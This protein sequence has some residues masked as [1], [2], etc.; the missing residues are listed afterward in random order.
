MAFALEHTD[1]ARSEVRL[2][3]TGVEAFTSAMY[4]SV[5]NVLRQSDLLAVVTGSEALI[6][7]TNPFFEP[8]EQ[9]AIARNL[10]SLGIAQK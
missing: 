1:I 6:V 9:Q 10:E 5:G 3:R 4:E 7:V 2:V 8:G